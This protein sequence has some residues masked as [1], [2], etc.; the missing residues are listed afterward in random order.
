MTN[1]HHLLRSYIIGFV[2]A[3]AL[4]IAAYLLVEKQ[5][6]SPTSL[7]IILTVLV[8]VQLI[9][10]ALFFFRLSTRSEDDRWNLITL[11]FTI[12]IMAIIVTGSLWIMYNLN[13]NMMN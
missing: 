4:T 6:M 7:Y 2:L 8:V 9:V 1:P 5:G 12:L 11:V 13:Y 10:Q 3:L